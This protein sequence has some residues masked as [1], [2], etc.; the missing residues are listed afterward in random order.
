MELELTRVDYLDTS[1]IT[2]N[3]VKFLPAELPKHQQKI[4]IGDQDGVIQL[5]SLKKDEVQVHFKTLPGPKVASVQLGG[6]PG[7]PAD[8][9]FV[10]I[11]NKVHGFNRKGKMFLSFDTN[12]TESIKSMFVSGADLLICGNHVYNHYR[13]CK[14]VGTYLCGDTIVDIAGLCPN[15]TSRI[16][17]VLACSGRVLRILEHSR[18][19]QTIELSSVPTILHVPKG[20]GDKIICGFTDG[21]V[22]LYK[23]SHFSMEI[24]EEILVDDPEHTSAISCLNTY[25]LTGDGKT[26]LIIGR[27]DGV[28]QIY[29]MKSEDNEIDLESHQLFIENYNES[30]SSVQ[31]GYFAANGYAEV[32]VCTYTGRIFG[33]TTQCVSRSMSDNQ[34][35][36]TMNFPNDTNLRIAKLRSEISELESRV[37]R[38]REKYQQSTQAMSSGLSAIPMLNVNDSMVLCRADASYDLSIEIPASIEYILLQSDVPLELLDVEKNTAVVSFSECNPL[39]GNC[40]LATYRCQLNT[41]RVDLKIRTIEGQHGTLQAFITPQLQP[42]CS[43]LR[44][45]AIKPLSLHVRIH[46]FDQNRPYSALTLKGVF[47]LSEMHSWISNCIPE[48]PEKLPSGDLCELIFENIL[49]GSQLK[50]E[51]KKGEAVFKSDNISTISIIKDVITREITKKR[52]KLEI[53]TD[54]HPNCI[55]HILNLVEPILVRYMKMSQDLKVLQALLELDIRSDDEMSVLCKEW[56]EIYRCQKEIIQSVAKDRIL[57]E[58]F[59]GFL[60]DLYIDWNKFRGTNV[61]SKIQQFVQLLENYDHDQILQFFG[62]K[63]EP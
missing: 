45:Y 6:A 27:R 54:M 37:A 26:E 41:N 57:V 60:T 59:H 7:T 16:V 43:Q 58:R 49:I 29:S 30:I 56:Q 13:D 51:Y 36:G 46:T 35:S 24:S 63:N 18:V 12:L 50:C 42:K 2:P 28:L 11:D 61:K 52:I 23:I 20:L 21:K 40:L 1:V 53:S 32:I 55:G 17:T 39:S 47:S 34:N 19:R 33:L 3:C 14:D 5:I 4:I 48:I 15:N 8:K 22:I 9:M 31:G 44:E 25:D 10:A 38:E 62:I